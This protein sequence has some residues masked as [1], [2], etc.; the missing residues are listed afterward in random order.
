[1][2]ADPARIF[3]MPSAESATRR[4]VGRPRLNTAAPA[5]ADA[6]PRDTII[7]AATRLFAER[8]YSQTTMSDIAREAGLQQSSL[9]YWFRRKELIVQEALVVNRAPLEFIGRVGAGSGSPALK[10]YR[11]LR[12][13][14]R[15]LAL[16]PIDFNEIE[17]I[18][19]NQPDEFIDFWRD[20]TRLHDWVV[21]LI[22]A[23]TDED[24]FI[25]C[26][27]DGTAT[28]LLCFNEGVQKRYRHQERHGPRGGNPF[29][30]KPLTAGAWAELEATMAVRSLLK[31]PEQ[32]SE[33]QRLASAF[34]DR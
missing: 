6:S 3:A 28:A 11:L 5:D 20:Y 25:D 30:H 10:L 24:L 8:G 19:E 14:T 2:S 21:S 34:D 31:D 23:A 17:R 33:I 13:D 16:S 4:P 7:A 1:M 9:Y 32:I 15:Q 29:A 22:R 12:F 26:D 18:A 27:P